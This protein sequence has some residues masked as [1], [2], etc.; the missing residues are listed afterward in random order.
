MTPKSPRSSAVE[1]SGVFSTTFRAARVLIDGDDRQHEAVLG[2][3]A[4][5]ANHHILDYLVDG[6]GVD[7]DTAH[8]D[9]FAL[10]RTLA[11]DHQGLS[12]FKD[13]GVFQT[14]VA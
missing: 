14:Q 10:P 5:V 3:M 4:P 11:I 8:G 2:Q 7:I 9:R 6:S 1:V 12:R 13:E